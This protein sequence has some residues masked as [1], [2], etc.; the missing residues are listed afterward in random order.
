MPGI[1]DTTLVHGVLD[2]IEQK[3]KSTSS[4]NNE[5]EGTPSVLIGRD[6][7]LDEWVVTSARLHYPS[8]Y[9]V[10]VTLNRG[11]TE[12]E[13][14]QAIASNL[15]GAY[16]PPVF[17]PPDPTDEE[18]DPFNFLSPEEQDPNS[19][20][21]SLEGNGHGTYNIKPTVPIDVNKNHQDYDFYL[22]WRL[23]NVIIEKF[24]SSETTIEYLTLHMVYDSESRLVASLVENEV[25]A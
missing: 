17:L 13:M 12:E 4:K 2:L 6:H 5:W 16:L 9:N 18:L 21:P 23:K 22:N 1:N 10:L 19:T 20:V 11:M 3:L 8:G 14:E 15:N 7:P 24:D 25:T